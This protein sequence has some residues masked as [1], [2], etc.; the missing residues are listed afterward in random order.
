MRAPDCVAC[1]FLSGKDRPDPFQVGSY[2]KQPNLALVCMLILCY[3]IFRSTGLVGF[4][5][6]LAHGAK[7]GISCHLV[8]TF[9]VV[10]ERCPKIPS[11]LLSS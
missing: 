7:K 10:L 2:M 6:F 3:V 1:R 8:Y 4:N 5:F 9:R 11:F